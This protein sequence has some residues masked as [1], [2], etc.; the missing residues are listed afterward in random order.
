MKKL[1]VWPK[2]HASWYVSAVQQVYLAQFPNQQHEAVHCLMPPPKSAASSNQT[3]QHLSPHFRRNQ[4][5]FY[6][7]LF[8]KWYTK[9]AHITVDKR[10]KRDVHALFI[11]LVNSPVESLLAKLVEPMPAIINP[12]QKED[13]DYN[14]Y[15]TYLFL[16]RVK[17]EYFTYLT[18][19]P[20]SWGLLNLSI[21]WT[22]QK[23]RWTLFRAITP[24]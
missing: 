17:Q 14:S 2:W 10:K 13:S 12:A 9:H 16:N 4:L 23:N 22:Q 18:C 20:S 6:S 19:I 7:H 11:N 1:D 5:Y 24:D 3:F 15:T 8:P 21:N